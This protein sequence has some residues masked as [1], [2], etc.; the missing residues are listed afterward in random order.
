MNRW[1]AMAKRPD[2][3]KRASKTA[4]IVGLVL[5]AINQGDVIAS[6]QVTGLA[7]AKMLLTVVVPYCVSTY[8][9][10]GAIL[11]HEQDNS[12]G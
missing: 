2:V 9:S 11:Q 6:G 10:V 12:L 4:A 1:F 3:I 8:S 7:A 5:I